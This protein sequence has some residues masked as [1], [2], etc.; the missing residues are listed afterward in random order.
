LDISNLPFCLADKIDV[1]LD[2]FFKNLKNSAGLNR[3]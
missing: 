2:E 1:P 3:T